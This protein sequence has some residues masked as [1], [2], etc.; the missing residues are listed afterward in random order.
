VLLSGS[1]ALLGPR[2]AFLIA[3]ISPY[4]QMKASEA[5]HTLIWP[6][7]GFVFLPWTTLMY[8]IAFPVYGFGWFLVGLGLVADI[9]SY[10][11]AASRRG[12]VAY[13]AGP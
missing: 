13:Y 7:L 2:F 4:G 11:A 12:D 6:L 5:F 8:L 10:A 9:A 3:L 1:L